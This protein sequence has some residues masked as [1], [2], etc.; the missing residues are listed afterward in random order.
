M[1]TSPPT[2]TD[3]S[4]SEDLPQGVL[5][6]WAVFGVSLGIL[7][8]AS[9]LALAIGV[10]MQ[11]VGALSWVTWAVTSLLVLGFA[12]ASPGSLAGS[13]PPA[14]STASPPAPPDAV[15]ATS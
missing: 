3:T 15:P 10:I 12:G 14:A 7:A 2:T 11:Q 1:T 6:L 5:P 8:P 4:T 13:P 9:T